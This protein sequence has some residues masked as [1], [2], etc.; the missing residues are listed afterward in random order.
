MTHGPTGITTLSS[1]EIKDVTHEYMYKDA[2]YNI[3]YD[4][5]RV[6]LNVQYG[7]G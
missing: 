2:Y 3:V 5:K 7:K 1:I 6:N 4:G